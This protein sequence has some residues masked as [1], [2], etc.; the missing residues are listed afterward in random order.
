MNNKTALL[1]LLC[2]LLF[3]SQ[4]LLASDDPC[5]ATPLTVTATCSPLSANNASA[6]NTLGVPDPGCAGYAG[7]DIWFTFTMPNYGY[8]T[9]LELMAGSMTDGGMAVYTGTDC[10]SLTLVA[11]DD[12]S[13]SG[14]MPMLTVDDGCMFEN[15][16][17]TFWVRVWENGNDNNGSFD[18]CAY[19]VEPSVIS[20]GLTCGSSLV[21]GDACCEAILLGEELDGYCANNTGYTDQP[22]E[23]TEF[24]ANVDNN[25]WLAFVATDTIVNLS[26]DHSNCTNGN[27]LQIAILETT[28]CNS[29]SIVSNCWN[30]T[31]ADT[32]GNIIAT[33][34]TIG[35]T[36]YIMIDGWA[37]DMCDYTFGIISGVQ[38]VDVSVDDAEICQGESTQLHAEVI[39]SGSYTYA[40]SP[41][42]GLDDPTSANPVATPTVSTTYTVT[43]T[44]VTDNIH[45][46]DVTVFGSAPGQPTIDGPTSVCENSLGNI[47]S[48]SVANTSVYNWA[49]SGGTINGGNGL[50]TILV[51][52]GSSNGSVC[53]T[54]ENNCGI[55]VQECIIVSADS[56]P[57]ISVGTP[58]I[59]CAPDPYDLNTIP[60]TNNGSGVGLLSYFSSLVDAQTGTNE[61][62]PP[63]VYNSGTYYVKMQTGPNCY[64][65]ESVDIEIEDPELLVVQPSARCSPQSIDL[66]MVTANE[67]NGFP[68]GTKTYFLDSLD[69]SN[70]SNVLTDTEVFTGGIY[71]VRYE[72]PNGCI[73][74]API[75]VR[76]DLTP[77]LLIIQ[78]APL[79]PGGSIDL[80]TISYINQNGSTFTETFYDNQFFAMNGIVPLTNTVVSNPQTYYIRAQTTNNCFNVY[81]I[82]ISAGVTPDAAISG[83]GTFCAGDST[84]L[85]FNLN[86]GGPFNVTFTDGS[87]NYTLNNINDG[88]LER[89]EVFNGSTTY[90]IVTVTDANGCDGTIMGSDV[91]VVS[92]M[93]PDATLSGDADI[94][95]SEDVTLTFNFNGTGPFDATY[96]DGT[97]TFSIND[98]LATHTINHNISTNTTFNLLSLVDDNG[99]DGTVSGSATITVNE[100]IQAN[101]VLTS[102]DA[103]FTSYTVSFEISG[104]NS[105]AYNVSGMSGTLNGNQFTSDPIASGNTYNFDISDGA[106]CPIVNVTGSYSC[107]CANDAGQMD[108]T[109]IEVCE[110]EIANASFIAGSSTVNPGDLF[111]YV[112]HDNAGAA[113]GTEFGRSGTPGFG[114]LP[115]MLIGV[116]YYISPIT[117]PDNGSGS[118]D[119]THTCFAIGQG[120]PV[121]FYELP[122][123]QISGDAT[124]C[125]GGS[126]DLIF[127]FSGGAGPFE[128]VVND[129]AVDIT[130]PNLTDGST[131]SVTP[132]TTTTY[133]IISVTDATAATCQGTGTGTATITV[134]GGPQVNNITFECDPTNTSYRVQFEIS[135]G[136]PA[137]YMVSGDPGTLD[138]TTNIFTSD[139]INSGTAYGFQVSDAS[140]CGFIPMNGNFACDCTSNAGEMEQSLIEVCADATAIADHLSDA[141]VL[142]GNDVLG[143]I[144]YDPNGNLP[145]SVMLTNSLPEFNYDS[146]LNY[147]VTY[148]IAAVSGNDDGSGFPVLDSTQDP[149]LSISNGQ[150]VIFVENPIATIASDLTICQGESA[151]MT[152]G[153]SGAGPFD[154]EYF[155]GTNTEMLAG[156]D[157]GYTMDVNPMVSTIYSLNSVR[158]SGS[159]ACIGS[160]DPANAEAEITVV[161]VPAVENLSVE[162]NAAGTAYRVVFEISGGNSANYSVNGDDGMLNG[163]EFTS[164]F[165]S[166]GTTYQFM[167]SD[168]SGCP[169]IE[170]TDT[171]YCN[172]TP[173]I[174]PVISVDLPVSC[175]GENDGAL[176]VQNENGVAPFDFVWSNGQAG[177]NNVELPSGWHYVTMTDG[178]NC[179]T[180]DSLFLE[181]PTPITALP[182]VSSPTCY[183][184]R[185]ASIYLDSVQGGSGIYT[186]SIDQNVSYVEN[187]FSNLAAGEYQVRVEDDNGCTWSET[188]RVEDPEEL[189]IDLGPDISVRL[190]DSVEI[191]PVT[192]VPVTSFSWQPTTFMDC[193]EC[194]EQRIY[195][196]HSNQYTLLAMTSDGCSDTDEILIT[197]SKDRPIF[198]PNIFSP[199]RDGENDLFEVYPGQSVEI[200]RTMKLYDRWGELVF[201]VDDI[202]QDMT[203]Y[204]WDGTL[205]G[206]PMKMGVYIYFLDV[207]FKDGRKE[208]ISGDVILAR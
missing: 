23:I 119:E 108:L 182:V 99:C 85:T 74:L 41:T 143:F 175:G 208:V 61:I 94:C 91:V 6:T 179:S 121:T 20:G 140:A 141:M 173:D 7:G 60:V 67:I 115:G 1:Q 18:I 65:I 136:D 167:V 104:G 77:D 97:S 139:W 205:R 12:N 36:Y 52:W 131:F 90:S 70:N 204:G 147:G 109:A 73:A 76:I 89:I 188:L 126:S 79:C 193:P 166:G 190:G 123:A 150:P 186:Y 187:M 8:H 15:A 129:G 14:N 191:I 184:D 105:A 197:V 54:A 21:A 134:N 93:A 199:N 196:T 138:N 84:D 31:V 177:I 189:I 4:S 35:N 161:E 57:D 81:P 194:F 168:G 172:C 124:I 165:L 27:G 69:A 47:F 50:D 28:D 5:S 37:G 56:Q 59:G 24:C 153:I 169:P 128:V 2:L 110:D 39:G 170:L 82:T 51:D 106:G 78:P 120:T 181:E 53:L 68:G 43:I 22:D 25:A 55:S 178:N 29:F 185:D 176:S 201:E 144:L 137:T 34:L 32:M 160:I 133:T 206:E 30:P 111:E 202:V 148:M 156:I 157:D 26:V 171:E 130:I 58:P 64:D 100:P 96:T 92:S 154:V 72:T 44:G 192:T 125:E 71:W 103:S 33:D 45:S 95:G 145:S 13:G 66:A 10:S 107:A 3:G 48:S 49:V 122:V 158:R 80:D 151:T 98:A 101:N 17:A 75:D 112:I 162:C 146:S 113:L 135:G 174:R 62:L 198:I 155:D 117:G 63:V 142:D 163:N 86:G 116:T 180:V 200:I 149:C 127:N 203:N 114:L 9:V 159:P 19:T 164:V 132:S 40:W 183:G 16:G 102:C 83:G 11:C 195:P 152:I 46:V 42:T 38:T 207:V 88:H 87:N 118:V